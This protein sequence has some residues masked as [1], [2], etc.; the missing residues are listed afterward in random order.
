MVISDGPFTKKN[1]N[2]KQKFVRHSVRQ[3]LPMLFLCA[4][5][6]FF[7]WASADVCVSMH[8][9]AASTRI[10]RAL[11]GDPCAGRDPCHVYVM[12][13]RDMS[14][15]MIVHWH[16]TRNYRQPTLF[17]DTVSHSDDAKP[18]SYRFNVTAVSYWM[19]KLEVPRYVYYANLM[20][21]TASTKYYIRVGDITEN[22]P[23]LLGLE[24]NFETAASSVGPNDTFHFVSGGDMGRTQVT[25]DLT[26][27]AGKTNPLF[28]AI[29][30]DLS[31]DNGIV[32][33]NARVA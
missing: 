33:V 3:G 7:A 28:A 18:S 30:G 6:F 2:P 13:G 5:M 25:Q 15:E 31:Y 4:I 26:D 17:F 19:S 12:V 1:L 8:P 14:R 9:I 27:L 20:S 11:A 22:G 29:G 16:S 32:R 24:W 10:S 21:L 23:V